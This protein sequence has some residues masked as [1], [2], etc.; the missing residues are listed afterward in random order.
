[1]ELPDPVLCWVLV[2]LGGAKPLGASRLC[3]AS[4]GMGDGQGV[5][6]HAGE[7]SL[8]GSG[9]FGSLGPVSCYGMVALSLLRRAVLMGTRLWLGKDHGLSEDQEKGT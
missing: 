2:F 9:L 1:M 4:R 3:E 5:C 7:M 6:A 8:G